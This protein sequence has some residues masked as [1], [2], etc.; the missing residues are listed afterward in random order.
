MQD[1]GT[2]PNPWWRTLSLAELRWQGRF[3]ALLPVEDVALGETLADEI[4]LQDAWV[5][6][7]F[8]SQI[9]RLSG[10]TRHGTPTPIHFIGRV[11]TLDHDWGRLM[12]HLGVKEGDKRRAPPGLKE[13]ACDIPTRGEV[14]AKQ[15]ATPPGVVEKVA[16]ASLYH[17]DFTCL[18]YHKPKV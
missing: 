2:A 4:S 16:V 17:D 7:H 1:S 11:E 3:K 8:E 9:L 18:G 14:V 12:D 13:H 15:R 6:E 5:D 10:A